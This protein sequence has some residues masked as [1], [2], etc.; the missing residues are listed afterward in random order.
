M[1]T[2]LET[3]R[4]VFLWEPRPGYHCAAVADGSR[5]WVQRMR[6]AMA[7][8][9]LGRMKLAAEACFREALRPQ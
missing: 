6:P 2:T 3:M 9:L 8:D 4:I 5:S 1:K 7:R